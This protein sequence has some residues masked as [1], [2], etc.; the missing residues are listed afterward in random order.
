MQ[1]DTSITRRKKAVNA[2][3]AFTEVKNYANRRQ[4][5]CKRTQILCAA[6]T[7]AYADSENEPQQ[8]VFRTV[9]DCRLLLP[10]FPVNMILKKDIHR[11]VMILHLDIRKF[12]REFP[13]RAPLHRIVR[14]EADFVGVEEV[15]TRIRVVAGQ[16]GLGGKGESLAR[17]KV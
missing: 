4:N 16:D 14:N 10:L 9:A 1:A 12:A 8:S 7:A 17:A 6:F 2:G 3:Q 13:V 11:V 15:D 5:G